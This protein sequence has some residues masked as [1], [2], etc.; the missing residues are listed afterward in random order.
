VIGYAW[1][2]GWIP[3]L[4]PALVLLALGIT[5]Y[6]LRNEL[7]TRFLSNDAGSASSRI[8]LIR[9]AFHMI[10]QHPFFG[11][12]ANNFGINISRYATPEFNADWLYTVHNRF[13]LIWAEDGIFALLAF[14]AFLVGTLRNGWR[15]RQISDQALALLAVG[16]TAG[17]LGQIIHMTVDILNGRQQVQLLVIVAGL[18]AALTAMKKE[19]DPVITRTSRWAHV[20]SHATQPRPAP[21]PEAVSLTYQVNAHRTGDG[22]R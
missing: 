4:A 13:V 17:V 11:V 14:I 10:E 16:M 8:P 3:G 18:L 21:V 12:G 5:V 1:Y 7:L 20:E 6:L 2:R 22:R 15:S 9:L 19:S